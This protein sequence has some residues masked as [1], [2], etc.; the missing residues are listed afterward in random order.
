MR[1]ARNSQVDLDRETTIFKDENVSTFQE[2]KKKKRE[3]KKCL[4]SCFDTYV[5]F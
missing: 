4:F 2:K 5:I 1:T 3:K